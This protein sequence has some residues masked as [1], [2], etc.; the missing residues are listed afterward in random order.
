MLVLQFLVI[1]SAVL[2]V[3][4]SAVAM[5]AK[6]TTWLYAVGVS[7]LACFAADGLRFSWLSCFSLWLAGESAVCA[8]EGE[9]IFLLT[10]FDSDG[11][12][13]TSSRS[14]GW[15]LVECD[16]FIHM[17]K[18]CI[19]TITIGLRQFSSMF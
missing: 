14:L 11:L 8:R 1:S 5:G 16:T 10:F 4:V 19:N 15:V 13:E 18:I 2:L 9:L 6:F 12:V 17:S 3:V 7:A